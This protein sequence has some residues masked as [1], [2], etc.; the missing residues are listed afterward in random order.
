VARAPA[1][2]HRPR[3]RGP[4]IL[5]ALLATAAAAGCRTPDPVREPTVV[6]APAEPF[7]FEELARQAGIADFQLPA[8][9]DSLVGRLGHGA[10]VLDY[11]RDGKPDLV[12]TAA[13][14]VALYRNQSGFRFRPVEAGLPGGGHWTGV[15]VGDVENDGWPDLFLNGYGVAALYRNRNGRF[16]EVTREMGLVA[17]PRDRPDWGT[18]A[19]F[20]D[21]DRD[22][23]VDL[24]VCRFLETGPAPPPKCPTFRPGVL[25]V[26][27][28]PDAARQ[29]PR[30]YHNLR[31]GRFQEVTDAWGLRGGGG[32]LSI[33]IRHFESHSGVTVAFGNELGPSE[34]FVPVPGGWR[35]AGAETGIGYDR[36]GGTRAV[37][38]LHW[39][40]L[41]RD[42]QPDLAM[43]TGAGAEKSLY[44]SLGDGS[45]EDLGW[46]WGLSGPGRQDEGFGSSLLDYDNDGALDLLMVGGSL[47]PNP[48]AL[49]PERTAE[50]PLRIF[51]ATGI[52][53]RRAA[54]GL[55]PFQ[56]RSVATADFDNDGGIDVIV[57][58]LDG[59]PRLL[60]N[61]APRGNWLGIELEGVRTN[62]MGIGARVTVRSGGQAQSAE[63]Q[64]AG[65]YLAAQDHRLLFGLGEA[66]IVEGISVQWPGSRSP[67][68]FA[69][70]PVNRWV[71]IRESL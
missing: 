65:G 46:R 58:A 20:A 60:R 13:G 27:P 11:N 1:S 6:A 35:E 3:A 50:Q 2:A 44:R 18:S 17:A 54:E 71:R 26:C 55:P 40:D 24:V 43:N 31:G 15:A 8:R 47:D 10:A 48:A 16:E 59:P 32:T 37:R 53:F 34:L 4:L 12:L 36:D 67:Q 66:G 49:R 56:G 42:G 68:E 14:R 41:D 19:G 69:V 61:S 63:V 30:V 51:H 64:T 62:R 23:W 39:G 29:S 70:T 28:A 33:A 52:T 21:L 22:G 38:S 5:G 45:L 7:P 57:T 9:D 25:A